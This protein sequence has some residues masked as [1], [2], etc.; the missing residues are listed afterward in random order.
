MKKIFYKLLTVVVLISGCTNNFEEINTNPN[1]PD[2][3]TNAGFLF[4]NAMRSSINT[5]FNTSFTRGSI[6]GDLLFNDFASNFA[7][8]T[9]ADAPSYFL[10]NYYDQIRELN[11]VIQVAE[12][13]NQ[14]NYKG[15]AL[16]M[17]SWMFQSLTDLYGPIPYSE[18]AKAKILGLATP[19]YENQPEVY[20]GLI[21]DL[22][23]A[24][25]LLGSNNE[26][27][28]GD[29][30][31]N[32][33][34]TRWKQFATGLLLRIA[35]RQSAKVDPTPLLTK[36]TGNPTQYPLISEHTDQ[37][38]LTYISD[39]LEN[40]SPLFRRSN[41]DYTTSTRV[42]EKLVNSL[43]S[44]ND[45]RLYVYALPTEAS[46]LADENGVRPDR[47]KFEYKG[48]TNGEGPLIN[49]TL[50][51]APGMLWAPNQFNP[52]LASSNAAQAVLISSSEIQFIL[53]EAAEQGYISGGSTAAEGYYLK[54]I[55]EQFSYFE[56]RIGNRYADSYLQ[57][58]S[59]DLI[60]ADTYY[61]Q[62]TVVYS[63]TKEEKLK[64]IWL[65]KWLSLYMC[66][67][68]SWSEVR[69][70]GYPE[71]VA[72]SQGPGYVGQRALYPADEQRINGANY[73]QAVSWLGADEVK[74]KLWWAK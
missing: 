39:R 18:A 30:L 61:Q 31:F 71:M 70:T 22:E 44:M 9:R 6:T 27:V 38:A 47:S 53:A 48:A 62:P 42:T 57:L 15:V 59:T 46:S 68:E 1:V 3:L 72:G 35:M 29:I 51:S 58:K 60:P 11:E 8:W 2:R 73:Q 41:S 28:L 55:Q 26:N 19:K 64:K 17:R 12:E 16:V 23:E 45:P 10:W 36:I 56:S 32:G 25:N 4:P 65:Q 24:L 37:V 54:G 66:G 33:D 43:K 63:G 7:N 5:Y 34:L 13:R 20:A 21:N 74:T 49:P 69:R 50:Y 40:E 67:F 14:P 52:A